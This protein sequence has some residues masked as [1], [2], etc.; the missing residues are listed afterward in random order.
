VCPPEIALQEFQILLK[1]GLR[2][3]QQ[4]KELFR[5][6]AGPAIRV[7][8]CDQRNLLADQGGAGFGLLAGAFDDQGIGDHAGP[9]V[10]LL[11]RSWSRLEPE[12]KLNRTPEYAPA[13]RIRVIPAG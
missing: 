10:L 9:A 5:L 11:A 6:A 3:P 13:G 1:R 12:P 8:A 7:K 2:A 4:A